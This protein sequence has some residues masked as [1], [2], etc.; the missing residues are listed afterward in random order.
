MINYIFSK[1]SFSLSLLCFGFL[2]L[3]FLDLFFLLL[4]LDL[5]FLHL[6]LLLFLWFY[7]SNSFW[8]ARLWFHE[9]EARATWTLEQELHFSLSLIFFFSLSHN[10]THTLHIAYLKTKL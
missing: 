1:Q 10:L 9:A 5:F 7:I 3:F 4:F 8:F 6:F 2:L